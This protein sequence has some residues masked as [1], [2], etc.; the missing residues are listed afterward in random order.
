MVP[1]NKYMY[2]IL[3][4]YNLK[5]Q[6]NPSLDLL[7]YSKEKDVNICS[8]ICSLLSK[9]QKIKRLPLDTSKD[10]QKC[11]VSNLFTLTYPYAEDIPTLLTVQ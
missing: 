6:A 1:N 3:V 4:Y 5:H 2:N 11:T 9:M 8:K 10:E 7:V